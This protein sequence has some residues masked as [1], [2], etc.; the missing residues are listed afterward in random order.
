[1]LKKLFKEKRKEFEEWYG[2]FKRHENFLRREFVFKP[3][4]HLDWRDECIDRAG[5]RVTLFGRKS[6]FKWKNFKRLFHKEEREWWD[7]L[8]PKVPPREYRVLYFDDF[9]KKWPHRSLLLEEQP[10]EPEDYT[11][12]SCSTR[13]YLEMPK[14]I[15]LDAVICKAFEV[16]D[17]EAGE[18][19]RSAAASNDEDEEY[20]SAEE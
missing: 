7:M 4:Y 5:P 11:V 6:V 3:G 18:D 9:P 2:R 10:D 8:P 13:V 16:S 12:Q 17:D 15:D 19:Q 20:F 14:S 1:M